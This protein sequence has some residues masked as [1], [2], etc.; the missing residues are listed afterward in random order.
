MLFLASDTAKS[1]R[2]QLLAIAKK[3]RMILR[4]AAQNQMMYRLWIAAAPDLLSSAASTAN[5]YISESRTDDGESSRFP[6][7]S[8]NM[9]S[10]VATV[11]VDEDKRGQHKNQSPNTTRPDCDLS[12]CFPPGPDHAEHSGGSSEHDEPA[13]NTGVKKRKQRAADRDVTPRPTKKQVL[14]GF[15]DHDLIAD[16]YLDNGEAEQ[17]DDMAPF[18]AV[19]DEIIALFEEW[20]DFDSEE[21]DTFARMACDD[22]DGVEA[23]PSTSM[24]LKIRM[25]LD[26]ADVASKRRPGTAEALFTELTTRQWMEWESAEWS[27]CEREVPRPSSLSALD[28]TAN[29]HLELNRVLHTTSSTTAPTASANCPRDAVAVSRRRSRDHSIELTR[30]SRNLK[31]SRDTT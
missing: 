19:E 2:K 30:D 24:E 20:R 1:R 31:L 11:L 25:F 14:P 18:D 8:K 7:V 17:D 5:Q 3:R 10:C 27:G 16:Q 13:D 22:H 15:E 12:P 9:K 6:N 29:H 28:L 26:R 4:R 23:T 21:Q